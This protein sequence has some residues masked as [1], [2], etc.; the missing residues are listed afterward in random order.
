M[1]SAFLI[2]SVVKTV[3]TIKA[4]IKIIETVVTYVQ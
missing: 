1:F 2:V 3:Y 4:E